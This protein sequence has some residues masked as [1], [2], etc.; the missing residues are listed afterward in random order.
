MPLFENRARQLYA[1]LRRSSVAAAACTPGVRHT[2]C[3]FH[4]YGRR[5]RQWCRTHP[6]SYVCS[7]DPSTA[8]EMASSPPTG[9]GRESMNSPGAP[10]MGAYTD[11]NYRGHTARDRLGA[12]RH[13]APVRL[14]P[15]E[16][17][18]KISLL[19]HCSP[20]RPRPLSC[21]ETSLMKSVLYS[22]LISGP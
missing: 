19:E 12:R 20:D 10:A 2:I 1:V 11:L 3:G 13:L 6:A 9:R 5:C 15:L 18:C 21:F 16:S 22:E 7:M 8:S 4:A 17:R 14:G